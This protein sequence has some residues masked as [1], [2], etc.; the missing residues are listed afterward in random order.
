MRRNA[1]EWHPPACMTDQR[2]AASTSKQWPY[3]V[4][5]I[6]NLRSAPKH[7][8]SHE[9]EQQGAAAS[10]RMSDS[11][12]ARAMT[13]IMQATVISVIPN[14]LAEVKPSV[15]SAAAAN[16]RKLTSAMINTSR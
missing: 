8:S 14:L 16:M 4:S 5:M 3:Y 2:A 10:S 9:A 1:I 15:S 11:A 6:K 7:Q 12:P 13:E